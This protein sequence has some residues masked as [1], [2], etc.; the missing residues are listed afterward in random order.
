VR[1]L[2]AY[3]TWRARHAGKLAGCFGLQIDTRTVSR[4][5]RVA[6][7]LLPYRSGAFVHDPA[8]RQSRDRGC[9]TL[10]GRVREINF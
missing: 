3:G 10:F 8:V 7:H 1:R 2:F 5:I 4:V 6:G 9:L